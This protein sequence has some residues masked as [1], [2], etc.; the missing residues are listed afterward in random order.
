MNN[1][2]NRTKLYNAR[3]KTKELRPIGKGR[4]GVVFV[5][6]ESSN[7][8]NPFAMKVVP[9]DLSAQNRKEVQPSIVEFRNQ[10]A[11]A[12]AAP[13]GVVKVMKLRRCDNFVNSSLINM[14]NVQNHNRT[15]QA[16]MYMEY[17]SGGDLL[18]WLKKQRTLNDATMQRIIS[19][20]LK[21]LYRIQKV[22]PY[23]RHNDLHLANVFVA[24]RGFLIGDFGWSRIKRNGTNPAVNTANGTRTA[25]YWGVGP[26]TDA[27][28][29]S[30]LFL[31]SMLTW[32]KDHGSK[33]F[34]KTVEFLNSV[35]PVGYRGDKGTY[36]NES[37]LIYGKQYPGLPTLATLLRTK[38]VN[39]ANRNVPSVVRRSI[40]RRSVRRVIRR[41][42]AV[43]VRRPKIR[44]PSGRM[45]YADGSAITL[46]YLRSLARRRRINVSG[47]R[48]KKAIVAKIFRV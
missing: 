27:R 42:R 16:I 44:G 46:T 25:S 13:G 5:V 14:P 4:Q 29:D 19:S 23:F 24:K 35:V 34:P 43:P 31:N 7:G 36:V 48:S 37:R 38:Y 2:S 17:C 12:S 20:I 21:T 11:A 30:H 22:Y 45:V 8:S 33:R 47:L 15:K 26:S 41:R 32:I 39:S 40:V 28:Y 1:C 6:S 3:Y 9:F 10:K 18:N